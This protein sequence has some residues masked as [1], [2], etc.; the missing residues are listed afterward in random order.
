MFIHFSIYGLSNSKIL[1]EVSENLLII[2]G[3][4]MSCYYEIEAVTKLLP[5]LSSPQ[6][7]WLLLT[8]AIPNQVTC[9]SNK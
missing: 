7:S 8:H 6:T 5:E 4:E 9:A 1:S 3:V 2:L